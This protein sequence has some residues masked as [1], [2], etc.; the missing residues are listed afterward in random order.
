MQPLRARLRRLGGTVVA[1]H[2]YGAG[3]EDFE[4][5]SLEVLQGVYQTAGSEAPGLV[6]LHLYPDHATME[7]VLSVEARRAG[8]VIDAS[9]LV[10]HEAWTGIPR[11]HA[12]LELLHRPQLQA[13]SLLG[14]EAVHSVLHGGLEYYVLELPA[15]GPLGA[16]AA[17]VAA[18]AVKDLE[19][20]EW[21]RR[22]GLKWLLEGQREY[23]GP[24]LPGLTCGSVEELGDALRASTA[25]LVE[26]MNPP[27]SP[28]C[29]KHLEPLWGA[30]EELLEEWRSGTGRPWRHASGV[31]RLVLGALEGLLEAEA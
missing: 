15:T 4:D 13:R 8:V 11:I 2:V 3:L 17:Q 9:Y 25:W 7:A 23:W 14:H 24:V 31:A 10:M 20:H 29:R 28:W 21:S 22:R 5:W 12:S 1:V 30:L 16:V 19:V 26:G 18:T 6:E 27:L